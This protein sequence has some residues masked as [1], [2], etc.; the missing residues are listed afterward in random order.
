MNLRFLPGRGAAPHNVS[1]IPRA[2]GRIK[3]R[4]DE[5]NHAAWS[6]TTLPARRMAQPSPFRALRGKKYTTLVKEKAV[7]PTA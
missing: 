5:L 1:L 7:M 3:N 2:R 6:G 4:A